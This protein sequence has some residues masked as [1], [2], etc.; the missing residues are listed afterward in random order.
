[1]TFGSILYSLLISPLQMFF[2]VVFGFAQK[3]TNNPGV[4]IIVLS[5]VMTN[6]DVPTIA[7]DGTIT[8]PVNPFT[9]NAIN[10]DEKTAH[11]QYIISSDD[12]ETDKNQG[13][14]F[15]PA[16]WYSVSSNLWDKNDWQEEA[17]NSLLPYTK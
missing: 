13:N 15:N 16:D 5:L 12:W 3:Y 2:E 7:T 9:G 10:S 6:G 14:T 1:M 17:K 4:S 8:N 11:R